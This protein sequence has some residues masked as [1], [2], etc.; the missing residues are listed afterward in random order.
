[1]LQW[2]VRRQIARADAGRIVVTL[3][4]GARVE[5]RGTKAGPDAELIIKRWRALARLLVGGS[6]G[7]AKAYMEG[8][9]K[10]S[11]LL[12]FL[13]WAALN[14]E[15]FCDAPRGMLIGRLI[16]RIRHLYRPNTRRGSRR[17]I[18]AHYDLG[19]EFYAL[20]LD[21]GMNYSSGIYQGTH[22]PL[23]DAQ[24]AKLERASRLLE[25]DGGERVLEIGCGWGP[26]TEKLSMGHGCK[27]TALTLSIE[28]L[29][30]ARSRLRAAGA[31]RGDVRIEDYRDVSGQYDRIVSIEMLE[32]VG[33]TYWPTFFRTLRESL[34]PGGRIVL[35][36][37]TID[38]R[39]FETYRRQP[40]FIQLYIFPGGILP[41]V[42]M[43]GEHL[44]RAGLR[45]RSCEF[46]GPSYALTIAAWRVRF[47]RAWPQIEKLGF[48]AR[49]KRMWDY[50]FAYCE[51]GFR[52]GLLNVGL[53][54]IGHTDACFD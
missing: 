10:S 1:V 22:Q 16:D 15:P 48:D 14:S 28:Q 3:P 54:Q 2:L 7:F 42:R 21:E 32:A 53:Y 47:E 52:V 30:Y 27:V 23:E 26:M 35:Q 45:L 18:A 38:E 4:S 29:E 24:R 31:T 9:W 19:N 50:Y 8:E 49:F 5:Q 36:S 20:W 44:A 17:N 40:D 34:V 43:I 37:I 13:E 11:S 41:T 25:L 39:L 12:T 33:E 6:T 51:V 46:F